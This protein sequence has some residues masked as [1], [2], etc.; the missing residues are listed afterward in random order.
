MPPSRRI[1]LLAAAALLLGGWLVA[2]TPTGN[3]GDPIDPSTL[4]GF[5]GSFGGG[6]GPGGFGGRGGPGGGGGGGRRGGGGGRGFFTGGDQGPMIR[7]EGGDIVNEDTLKTARDAPNHSVD[8][9]VWKNAP[10]YENDTYT[11]ARILFHNEVGTRRLGWWV[12]FPDADINFSY[13]LQQVSSMKVNPDPIVIKLT[14][15]NL[16]RYPLIYMEHV[17]YLALTIDEAKA[18]HNYLLNGGTLLINDTWGDAAFDH[19]ADVM[20]HVLPGRNWTELTIDHPIFHC[21]FD[22]KGPMNQLQ[23]PTKQFLNYAYN[24]NDPLSIPTRPREYGWQNVHFRAWLDDKKHI[25]ILFINNSD[26]SDG[27]EREGEDEAYFNTFSVRRA[28]PIGF[29]VIYYLLTN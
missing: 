29:N 27:W 22:L 21:I 15:P 20:S 8:L 7:L 12:D 25:T 18:L 2:Q 4:G 5:G 6:G 14:D 19:F 26:V 28:Y 9:P 3:I 10:G 23:V 16:G 1:V 13:R 24:P 11:F 17:E